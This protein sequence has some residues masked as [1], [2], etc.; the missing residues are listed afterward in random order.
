M[1]TI[2][3]LGSKGG[4]GK[5]SLSHCLAYGA[6]LHKQQAVM[7][8]TDQRPPIKS[9]RPYE[10]LDASDN[11]SR[12]I[13]AV[14]ANRDR[15]GL[16]VIDGAGNRPHQDAWITRS[17]DMVLI[18]VTNSPE[19]VRCALAD[20]TRL[21]DP[22]VYVVVNRWPTNSLVRAVMQR[23]IKPLPTSRFAGRLPEVGAMRALLEDTA[24][25]TPPTK[26]NNL[27]RQFYRLADGTLTR[28]QTYPLPR[29]DAT[30]DE[31]AAAPL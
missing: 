22:K 7:A 28:H 26:V 24:W 6:Y 16:M 23:Y 31:L 2:A 12:V 20:L 9:E 17:V 18:P 15:D 14:K 11:F 13:S 27:A 29:F 30:V 1:R 8:H 3:I 5:T 10:Y 21:A 25:R 19:D 4:T